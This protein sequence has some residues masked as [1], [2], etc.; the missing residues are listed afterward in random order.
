MTVGLVLRV[1]DQLV[2][3]VGYND[4]QSVSVSPSLHLSISPSLHL[5]ISPSLQM[6]KNFS[7]SPLCCRAGQGRPGLA[8]I[9]TKFHYFTAVLSH[10]NPEWKSSV[11]IPSRWSGHSQVPD[12]L[13]LI[14]QTWE[15]VCSP[16]ILLY[17]G[18]I[19]VPSVTQ[20]APPTSAQHWYRLPT[21]EWLHKY[22]SGDY[23]WT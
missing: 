10:S 19:N 15:P 22:V 2:G 23:T 20:L 14:G 9:R 21:N 16:D 12:I 6:I 18:L 3:N 1:R 17:C 13:A 4:S 7:L 8:G 5:S 11:M